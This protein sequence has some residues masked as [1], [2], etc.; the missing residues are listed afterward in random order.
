MHI[1]LKENPSFIIVIGENE[2]KQLKLTMR[3]TEDDKIEKM[4]IDSFLK[5]IED[6]QKRKA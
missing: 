4:P 3:N 6:I 5:K 1:A 2:K